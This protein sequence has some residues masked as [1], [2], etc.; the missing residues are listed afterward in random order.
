[1]R[2]EKEMM[3][4]ILDVAKA[5]KRIRA[6]LLSGSRAN[7]DVPKDIYQDYDITYFVTDAGPFYNNT[8][9]IEEKF[10]KPAVMQLPE[11][12]SHPLLPPDGD[13]H[14]TYLMIFN[15]CSRIDLSIEF[16]PYVDDGEPV[17]VLLDKDGFLPNIVPNEKHWYIKPPCENI[18]AD[19]CNE[20][21]WCLNNV[22]KGIARDELPYAMD[23]FNHHVRDMLNQMVEWTI[24]INTGFSVSAGKMGKYFR[25]YLPQNLYGMYTKT[26]SDSNYENFWKSVF[27]ACE[28]FRTMAIKVAEHFG[29]TYNRSED[30]N[31]TVY[32]NKVKNNSITDS[33]IAK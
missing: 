3:E 17:V 1:M 4:L 11:L 25:K 20:F 28:L 32:L 27:T 10:G 33:I 6:V 2:S 21:W 19:S 16:N 23:M 30:E 29:F 26:Y 5:D 9:W 18:Y 7:P 24:G 15:D 22:A 13:G 14:F 8:A 12:M 31:M